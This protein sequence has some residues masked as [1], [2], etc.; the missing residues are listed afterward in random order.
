MRISVMTHVGSVRERNEDSLLVC[1]GEERLFAGKTELTKSWSSSRSLIACVADGM[2][3]HSGGAEA[4][5]IVC[6][7]LRSRANDLLACKLAAEVETVIQQVIVAVNQAIHAAQA[8]DSALSGMGS[9]LAGLLISDTQVTSFHS[10]DSRIYGLKGGFLQQ[11]TRDH[12]QYESMKRHGLEA[13]T[14]AKALVHCLGGGVSDNFVEIMHLSLMH[15]FTDYLLCSDGVYEFCDDD[16]L[17]LALRNHAP[18]Q[19]QR[20]VF[21]A[22]AGDNLSC[23]MISLQGRT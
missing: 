3:G 6:E 14:S 10:G 13:D 12:N 18:E 21:A 7:V 1:D 11:I 15:G 4:S 8:R 19:I 22:G 20:A 9:T 23:V 17:E 2:G 16:T 5:R